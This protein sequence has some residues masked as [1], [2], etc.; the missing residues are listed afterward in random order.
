[1]SLYTL[2][3]ITI[4]IIA[5]DSR[6]DMCTRILV[7]TFD[8][9]DVIHTFKATLKNFLLYSISFIIKDVSMVIKISQFN[10]VLIPQH[11]NIVFWKFCGTIT[12][13]IT[14]VLYY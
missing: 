8:L 10:Y 2:D 7:A 13:V 3:S 4:R 11:F 1:M 5:C 12:T 6:D 9:F 14:Y